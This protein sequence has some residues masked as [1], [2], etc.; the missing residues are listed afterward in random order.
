MKLHEM[1]SNKTYAYIASIVK[2]LSSDYYIE[3]ALNTMKH[4]KG[5][6]K[7]RKSTTIFQDIE[8]KWY[9]SLKLNNPIYEYY[10]RIEFVIEAWCCFHI[11]SKK[12]IS[13]L[14]KLNIGEWNVDSVVDVGCGIGF[15]T[16]YLKYIFPERKI[17]GT[18]VKGFQYNIANH[19]AKKNGFSI[20]ENLD[21]LSTIDLIFASEYFEHFYNPI[22]HLIYILRKNPKILIIANSFGSRSFCHFPDYEYNNKIYSNKEIGK[23]FNNILRNNGYENLDCGFWNNR[24][25][26]WREKKGIH[27]ERIS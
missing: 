27:I 11:Y 7:D 12:Y 16:C 10:S 6:S 8:N 22:E 15:S 14:E 26:V 18:N 24:P 9:E 17:Y 13:M 1:N 5:S 3:L 25:S 19:L 4:H 20:M 2:E 21:S 23:I